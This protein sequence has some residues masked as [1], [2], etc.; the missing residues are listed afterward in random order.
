M[1]EEIMAMKIKLATVFVV[2]AFLSGCQG[3]PPPPIQFGDIGDMDA[4]MELSNEVAKAIVKH[5]FSSDVTGI[6]VTQARALEDLIAKKY[7]VVLFVRD[8][9]LK[10]V[11]NQCSSAS[12]EVV[13]MGPIHARE[14][15]SKVARCDL[16]T[17]YKAVF[18]LIAR[19]KLSPEAIDDALAWQQDN[20]ATMLQSALYYLHNNRVGEFGYSNWM[21]EQSVQSIKAAIAREIE[22]SKL[23]F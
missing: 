1:K 11:S 8:P 3:P 22:S 6:G 21:P 15:L 9:E 19:L 20:K 17:K 14:Q 16:A 12:N 4:K 13:T 5:G 10:G 18:D 2:C 7:D 23:P